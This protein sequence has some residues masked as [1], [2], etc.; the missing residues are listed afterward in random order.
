[1][2]HFLTLSTAVILAKPP[3]P[4]DW[5]FG[6]AGVTSIAEFALAIIVCLWV[7][8]MYFSAQRQR[9]TNSPRQLFLD[10]CKAHELSR[11]ERSL[12]R[13]LAQQ[14]QLD[15]PSLLFVEPSWFS[16][17]K[18]L[19]AWGRRFDELDQLRQRIFASH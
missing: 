7:M 12:L 17:E 14:H 19:P 2:S 10:L 16:A 18:T 6:W 8:K 5:S 1:M 4:G 3:Q 15:Q 9:N 11:H 13:R